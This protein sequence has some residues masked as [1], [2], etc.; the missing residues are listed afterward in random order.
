[1][2]RQS[3]LD[4]RGE[5]NYFDPTDENE[6]LSKLANRLHEFYKTESFLRP[7]GL[8][9][10]IM[11]Q[12]NVDSTHGINTRTD[13]Q[14]IIQKIIDVND[15]EAYDA[16]T[17]GVLGVHVGYYSNS[18]RTST[19][20]ESRWVG[21]TEAEILRRIKDPT[22]PLKHL[23][24][25]DKGKM[26]LNIPN[27]SMLVSFRMSEKTN[28]EDIVEKITYNNKQLLG[29]LVRMYV[30]PTNAELNTKDREGGDSIYGLMHYVA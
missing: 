13:V 3:W 30:S 11:Y 20:Q 6:V 8:S 14:T 9:R 5:D 21:S 2:F 29:R 23:I 4:D 24:V 17:I 25:V 7:F 26:G 15:L 1:M 12:V 22:D 18:E 19:N 27:L 28:K 10:S 16:S